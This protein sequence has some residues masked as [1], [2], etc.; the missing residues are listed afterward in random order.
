MSVA[1]LVRH[2]FSVGGSLWWPAHRS[3]SALC[4]SATED[5]GEGKFFD[6][7][8]VGDD[9]SFVAILRRMEVAHL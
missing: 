7:L 3:L 4:K 6:I 5:G 2:S 9:L 1:R 8:F